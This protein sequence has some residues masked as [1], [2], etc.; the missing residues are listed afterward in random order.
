M[1]KIDYKQLIISIAIPLLLGGVVGFLIKDATKN[2]NGFIPGYIF[3]VVWTILYILMGIASYLIRDDKK[4]LK[5]YSLNLV[6]NFIWPIIFFLLNLKLLALV[7]LIILIFV[8]IYM[9][10]SFYKKDK[11]SGYLLMPYLLWL[12]VAFILNVVEL[13][14]I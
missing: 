14:K 1:K 3:P 8:V 4:L 13:F 12:F 6:I 7:D 11:L 5:T 2:Y 10:N 9:I